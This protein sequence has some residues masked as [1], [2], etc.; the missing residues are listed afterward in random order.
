MI[1][2]DWSNIVG[3]GSESMP[4]LL[5]MFFTR[6]DADE[7]S[8][9]YPTE[10]ADHIILFGVILSFVERYE[11]NYVDATTDKSIL[12]RYALFV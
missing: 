4:A 8:L 12:L 2:V 11:C 9:D 7:P 1:S 3:Q 6:S 10:V 5:G